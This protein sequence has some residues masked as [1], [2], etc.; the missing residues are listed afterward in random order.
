LRE[1]DKEKVLIGIILA[2][3]KIV[4]FSYHKSFE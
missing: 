3:K 4:F 2:E 1:I